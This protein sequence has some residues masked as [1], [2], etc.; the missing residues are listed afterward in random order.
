MV[1]TDAEAAA[2]QPVHPV[3]DQPVGADALD[4]RAQGH[5]EPRQVLH[6]GLA[7][8]VHISVRPGA[9]TAA[10]RAFSVAVTEASS[11]KISAPRRPEWLNR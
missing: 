11:R 5:E 2:A 1:R 4:P 10:I 7:G 6:V 8:R 9:S 3:H